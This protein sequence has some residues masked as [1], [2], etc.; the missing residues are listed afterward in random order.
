VWV[1]WSATQY[2]IFAVALP[3]LCGLTLTGKRLQQIHSINEMTHILLGLRLRTV[4]LDFT[5][6]FAELVQLD[7]KT[8]KAESAIQGATT[9]LC[10]V[11]ISLYLIFKQWQQRKLIG[12][13]TIQIRETS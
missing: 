4:V 11:L 5:L 3:A 7:T 8:Q 6:N 2:A 1:I 12:M 9:I 13:E 10:T